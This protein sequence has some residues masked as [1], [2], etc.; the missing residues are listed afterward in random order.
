MSLLVAPTYGGL[1]HHD[2][3]HHLCQR[4]KVVGVLENWVSDTGTQ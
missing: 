2:Y 1:P 4:C 3:G